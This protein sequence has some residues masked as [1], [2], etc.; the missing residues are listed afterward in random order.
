MSVFKTDWQFISDHKYNNI[1]DDQ[2]T[3]IYSNEDDY[4]TARKIYRCREMYSLMAKLLLSRKA[5]EPLDPVLD[6]MEE[7]KKEID[8]R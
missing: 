4:S 2:F 6:E 5:G 7:L 1:R 3:I 8:K